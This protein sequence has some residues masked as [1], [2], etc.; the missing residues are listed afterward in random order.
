MA[1]SL[2]AIV[3]AEQLRNVRHGE[4]LW[5][6]EPSDRGEVQI[7]DVGYIEDGRFQRL[8]NAVDGS[9]SRDKSLPETFKPL[10][11]DAKRLEEVD[12]QFLLPMQPQQSESIV[13]SETDDLSRR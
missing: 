7:G 5:Q 13:R 8:F 3:Y 12:H 10:L 2:A 1:H 11:Y 9:S 4:P 6:P